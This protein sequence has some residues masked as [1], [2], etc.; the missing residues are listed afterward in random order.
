MSDRPDWNAKFWAGDSARSSI[1]REQ[2]ED[3][4]MCSAPAFEN[5]VCLTY[6]DLELLE[7]EVLSKCEKWK[8]SGPPTGK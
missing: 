8:G 1:I 7:I 3:E 5:F 6:E 2:D 4:I